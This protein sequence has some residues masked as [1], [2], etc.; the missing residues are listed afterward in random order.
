MSRNRCPVHTFGWLVVAALA[1]A[2]GLGCSPNFV[3]RPNEDLSKIPTAS[4]Y[5]CM[6]GTT[7]Y[8]LIGGDSAFSLVLSRVDV[9]EEKPRELLLVMKET[10]Q[11][12]DGI[13]VVPAGKYR[14]TQVIAGPYD[15]VFGRS[16]GQEK[17]RTG[18][19][20]LEKAIEVKPSR[21]NFIGHAKLHHVN[22]AADGYTV[23]CT[24]VDVEARLKQKL[25]NIELVTDCLVSSEASQS[26]QGFHN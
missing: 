12:S 20:A 22:G 17:A 14:V 1:I 18:S 25:A 19:G 24:D 13:F 15:P 3:Q 6:A 11:V 26:G 21:A 16:G 10:N 7:D 9:I 23:S 2:G 4:G 8:R 5:I